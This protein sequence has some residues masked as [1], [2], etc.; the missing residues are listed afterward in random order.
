MRVVYWA[1]F[2]LAKARIIE[3]LGGVAGCD[4]DVVDTLQQALAALP[5]ADALVLFDAPAPEAKQIVQALTAPGNT[6]RWMHFISAGREG[7]EAAGLPRGIVISYAAGAVAATVAEHAMALMLA[8]GRRLP[9]LAEQARAHRWDRAPS[10]RAT[11]LEGQTL[12][13]VGYGSIGRELARRARPFGMRIVAVTRSAKAGHDVDAVHGLDALHEVLGTADV[14]AIAIALNNDTHHLFDG[15]AL[16]A[17]KRGAMIINVAR[18]GVIDQ[19]A[20]AEALRSGQIGSAGLDVTDPEPLPA[21]DPLWDAPNLLISPHF[22]GGGSIASVERIAAGVVG[23]LKRLMAGQ[24]LVDVVE[25]SSSTGR[26][27]PR[28][29]PPTL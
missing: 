14:V 2:A 18:G 1:R 23:N 20:L 4:L 28:V 10:L 25:H 22:A 21:G 16:A 26:V 3:L 9:E 19:I 7:F 8:I 12:A 24:P 5:A 6:V 15:A 11:S 29:P 17:C 27:T 13:I